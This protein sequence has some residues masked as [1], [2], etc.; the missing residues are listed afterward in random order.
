ME[1]RADILEAPFG[2]NIGVM[3]WTSRSRQ[4]KAAKN[5]AESDGFQLA[6]LPTGNALRGRDSLDLGHLA[7]L[8]LSLP[9][10]KVRHN[11]FEVFLIDT[12]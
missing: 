1:G 11:L 3:S 8:Q 12:A 7:V 9:S 5:W 6:A 2:R 10:K 4:G